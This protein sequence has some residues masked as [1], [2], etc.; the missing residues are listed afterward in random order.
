M[1]ALTVTVARL[2]VRFGPDAW[3]GGSAGAKQTSG[4]LTIGQPS[5]G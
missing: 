5:V 2:N 3:V 1:L 4:R